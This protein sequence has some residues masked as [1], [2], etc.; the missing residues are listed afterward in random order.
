MRIS[1]LS[2]RTVLCGAF[3]LVSWTCGA[4]PAF[5]TS[6]PK[7]G[8]GP[9]GLTTAKLCGL[10][11]PAEATALLDGN[12][13]TGPGSNDATNAEAGTAI[14]LLVGGNGLNNAIEVGPR[15]GF[16]GCN[17]NPGKVIH[18][19]GWSGCLFKGSEAYPMSA[20]KG[21][22]L[23]TFSTDVGESTPQSVIKAEEATTTHLFKV[24]HS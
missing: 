1:G 12:P 4:Q 16:T 14:C 23:I 21:N 9:G 18:I 20:Y 19:A 11:T 8:I 10:I 15:K 2:V 3:I 22:L 13:A 5:A 17:E 7:L 6:A 24:L